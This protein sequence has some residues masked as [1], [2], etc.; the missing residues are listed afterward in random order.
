MTADEWRT[1]IDSIMRLLLTKIDN[2]DNKLDTLLYE[3][4]VD[5]GPQYRTSRNVDDGDF[6]SEEDIIA[7]GQKVP[8]NRI[9]D[10]QEIEEFRDFINYVRSHEKEFTQKEYDY[11]GFADKN[12][13]DVRLSDNSRRVLG[14]AYSKVY[15]KPWAF[16][17]VR[18]NMFKYK[19]SI[20]WR[21]SDGRED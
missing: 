14:T 5:A 19:G 6:V 3:D 21:W 10:Q 2:I 1:R 7:K 4:E 15:R 16:N 17:F 11:S 13:S 20:A 9:D 8:Y 12:F 18:G